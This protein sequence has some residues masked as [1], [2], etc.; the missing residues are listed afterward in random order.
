M[1]DILFERRG[2]AGLITLNRPD[3]LNAIT[4]GMVHALTDQLAAWAD[5]RAVSRVI[6]TAAGDRAFCAGGDLR[7]LYDLGRA[8]R[9]DEA[10]SFWRDE[11]RLVAA[12]KR[13]RKPLSRSSTGW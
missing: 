5:D 7:A 4:H 13:Y 12:I 10:L 1:S 8:G 9:F 2:A 3:A 11:Y 6:V